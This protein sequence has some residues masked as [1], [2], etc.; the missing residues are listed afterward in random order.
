MGIDNKVQ[1]AQIVAVAN[2]NVI[3]YKNTIPWRSKVDLN[4][5]KQATMGF[6]LVMGRK[7]YESLPGSLKGRVVYIV[8]RDKHYQPEKIKADG[9][10]VT[11]S[12]REAID[13]AKS[14]AI[15]AGVKVVWI[16]GGADIYKAALPFTDMIVKTTVDLDVFGDT[17][18]PTLDEWDWY[19]QAPAETVKDGD[20]TLTFERFGKN[21]RENK[22]FNK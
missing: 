5:F 21:R 22:F 15:V 9:V 11:H 14:W 13:A 8:T 4:F 2:D 17:Y 10:H 18:Y 16:C 7:T 19:P 1:V 20:L 6:P 3:G 12:V